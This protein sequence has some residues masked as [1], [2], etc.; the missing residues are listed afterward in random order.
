MTLGYN[1]YLN[2]W[3]RVQFN[4]E[5]AWFDQKVR[6]GPGPRGLLNHQDTLMTR[7]QFVF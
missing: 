1:W 5:H 7:L 4:W 2:K 3:V 6:L